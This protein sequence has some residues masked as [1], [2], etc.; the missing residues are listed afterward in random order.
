[1]Q[2]VNLIDLRMFS[3]VVLILSL[4]CFTVYTSELNLLGQDIMLEGKEYMFTSM[5]CSIH[6]FKWTF[7]PNIIEQTENDHPV[8]N[9][10]ICNTED[11]PSTLLLPLC[12]KMEN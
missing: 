6:D 2:K 1:M 4:S 9:Y 5:V 11:R 12:R 7:P 10:K 3:F 8:S